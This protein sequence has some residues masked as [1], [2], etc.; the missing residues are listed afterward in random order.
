MDQ[1]AEMLQYV[2]NALAYY[3]A[4]GKKGNMGLRYNRSEHTMRVYR[5]AMRL[6]AEYPG[7]IDLDSLKIAAI[8]HDIGY[9]IEEDRAGHAAHGAKLCREYLTG[10]HYPAA[11]IDFI[12]ELIL[13]HSDKKCINEDIPP[14]LILL[15]EADLLDDTGAQGIVLDIWVEARKEDTNYASMLSHIREYTLRAMQKDCVRTPAAKRIWA[16]KQALVESFV[17]SLSFD[18]MDE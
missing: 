3:D 17:E 4:H 13:R 7:K 1:Y 15:M 2:K 14:E 18:L 11:Q 8:F 5:W 6:A 16:K 12:C 9:S 10:R